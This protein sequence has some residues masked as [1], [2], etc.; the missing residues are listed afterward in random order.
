MKL[1]CLLKNTALLF[2]V[3][4]VSIVAQAEAPK[5]FKVGVILPLTGPNASLGNYI[6]GGIELA[7]EHQPEADR[8]TVE[9]L[10]EDDSWQPSKAV[11]AFRKLSDQGIN[12][13][14]VAGSSIGN[15]LAPIAEQKKIPLI[16]IGASDSKIAKGRS[17]AFLHWVSPEMESQVMVAEMKRRGYK[18]IAIIGSQQDGIIA[19]MNGVKA[20]LA[21]ASMSDRVVLEELFLPTETDFKTYLAKARNLKVDGV[22]V[23][24]LPGGLS[25]FAKQ[26]KQQE[27]KA[28]LMGIEFFEDENEVKAAEGA[29]LG[30]WYVNADSSSPKFEKDY[31][32][33]FG[34]H[35]G[36]AAANAYD[37]LQL[38]I[39]GFKAQG[40]S[41]D[42]IAKYL[43]QIKDYSGATGTYSAT[44]D[45]RFTLPAAVKVVT[46]DGFEKLQG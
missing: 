35:P 21:K 38:L 19:L 34:Y 5:T 22:V 13:I 15:T 44:G 16:A 45:G 2:S 1:S 37:S 43:G 24:L 12:A 31:A 20:E 32:T 28:D 36:W 7:H 11:S 9:L 14:L 4:V 26:V 6:K 10:F 8:K 30:Q 23:C 18:N 3:F 40:A 42:A 29:L 27:L 25:S 46:Q 17:Y 41:G 39:Q 33:K